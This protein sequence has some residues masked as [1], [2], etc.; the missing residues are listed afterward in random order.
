MAPK[1]CCRCHDGESEGA[2]L[3]LALVLG[4]CVHR[5]DQRTFMFDLGVLVY[6]RN[7]TAHIAQELAPA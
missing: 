4:Y 2:N 1:D 3:V 6:V 5:L 7:E